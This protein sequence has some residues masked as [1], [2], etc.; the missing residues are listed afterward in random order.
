MANV[1]KVL[2]LAAVLAASVVDVMALDGAWRGKLQLGQMELPLVFNFKDGGD[3][4]VDCTLDSPA[5]GAK[6][7]PAEVTFCS[8]DSVAVVCRMIGASYSGSVTADR[9]TGNFSQ[10]GMSLPLLL[11]PETPLSE[12]RPQTPRPPYPYMA[13][14][15]VFAAPDGELMSAT[16]TMPEG[17]KK[18]NVPA[19][20][21]VTGSGAQNRDEEL[22]DHKPFAVIADYLAR[23][24]VASLRYDDRGVGRSGGDFQKGTTD[25]FK[26][27]AAAAID[28]LRGFDEVG[29]VG[30]VGHSEGGTIALMLAGEGKPDFVISLAGMAESGKQTLMRQNRR[31]LAGSGISGEQLESCM[32]LIGK[33]FDLVAEQERTGE[34]SEID[35]AAVSASEGLDVDPMIIAS[36][37]SSMKTRTPWFDRFVALDPEDSL[38]KIKCAVLAV[39]GDKD[40]QVDADGNLAVIKANV[41]Q[42]ETV[43]AAGLNHLMQHAETGDISEYDS[44]TETFA[45]EVLE[46]MLA[47]I[48][49][50]Q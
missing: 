41:P 43:K 30:V 26:D 4:K 27:D 45:P 13:V 20:V 40:T 16:L 49:G 1:Y 50:Q 22:M 15:T 25:T 48:R 8:A 44:I 47:F 38:K 29:P 28:F 24:G 21:M 6:G 35:M 14:D 37:Q 34:K 46:M 18:G 3:G 19:V 32:A 12:R 17:W 11:T 7:I 23:N 31:A 42:A 2:C 36:L 33:G 10:R 5:Q 9:I 39:N